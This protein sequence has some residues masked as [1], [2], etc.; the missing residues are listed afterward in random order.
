MSCTYSSTPEMF[1]K[2]SPLAPS[3]SPHTRET[4][5][6]LDTKPAPCQTPELGQWSFRLM[7]GVITELHL[8]SHLVH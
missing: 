3:Y 8:A 7:T 5:D 4:I 2:K 6:R 1:Y